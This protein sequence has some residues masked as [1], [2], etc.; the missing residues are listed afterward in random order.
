MRCKLCD[1]DG[2]NRQSVYR[3]SLALQASPHNR[4]VYDDDTGEAICLDCLGDVEGQLAELE[5]S[6]GE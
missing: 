4:L 6:D 2:T 1:F 3:S 5:E